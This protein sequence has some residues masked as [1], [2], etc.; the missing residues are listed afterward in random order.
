[1]HIIVIVHF[2]P[3]TDGVIMSCIQMLVCGVIALIAGILFE[4]NSIEAIKNG[5]AAVLYS[6]I[7]GS[8]IG[9]TLQIV[10]QK[11]VPAD[12][13]T[14]VMSMES[15]F[16]AIFGYIHQSIVSLVSGNFIMAYSVYQHFALLRMDRKL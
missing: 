13:A 11:D 8:G 5:F 15:V 3:D 10:A 2:A 7:M 1:M 16:G 6:G 14:I 12:L 9:F 4:T